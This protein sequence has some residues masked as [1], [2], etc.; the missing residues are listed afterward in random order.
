M[1]IEEFSRIYKAD[2]ISSRTN[3]RTVGYGKL[4]DRKYRERERSFLAEGV[5]LTQEALCHAQKYVQ[6]VLLSRS[7]VERAGENDRILDIAETAKGLHVPVSIFAD[8][9]FEKISTE[10]A[11]QG[12]IAVLSYLNDLHERDDF[13]AWQKGKRLLMLEEIRD[14]GNLGT[15]LRTAEALGADGVILA[16]CADLYGSKVVRAAMGSLFRMPAYITSDG[17]ACVKAM[18]E[19]GR[20]V[21]AAGLGEHTMT[22]GRYA[23]DVGDCV[24]IGNEG[25]GIS[26]PV[27]EECTACVRIPMT[28]QTESLNASVAAACILWEYFRS[29]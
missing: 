22:L 14:P 10:S 27:L 3:P 17:Q 15:V 29:M 12:V 4:S 19:E 2:Y 25:H 11:P 16:G 24:V 23:T 21:L 26:A 20:R 13:S 1:K 6:C 28:G 8:S 9:A 18:K 5:K 7:A